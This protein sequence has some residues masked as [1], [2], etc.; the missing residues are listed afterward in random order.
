MEKLTTNSFLRQFEFEGMNLPVDYVKSTK[1]TDGV[2]CD[3][4]K[5]WGDTKKDLGIIKIDAGFK[6]PLQKVLGGTKTIEGYI[7]G[8]GKITI[9]RVGGST[10]VITVEDKPNEYLSI[11]VDVGDTMQWEAEAN[12]SL[13]VFE[14]CYPPYSDG[15]FQNLE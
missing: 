9:N 4:Y 13:V 5:F 8:A 14:V 1:V 15:R 7:S 6:T 11:I 10:E 3:E 12:S 2:T